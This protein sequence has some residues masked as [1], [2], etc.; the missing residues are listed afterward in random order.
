MPMIVFIHLGEAPLPDC[1]VDAMD[2]ARRISPGSEIVLIAGE[3]H[4]E[5]VPQGVSLVVAESLAGGEEMAEFRRRS[6]LRFEFRND[7]WFHTSARFFILAEFMRQT[8]VK[9]VI[10]LENDVVLHFDP[11]QRIDAFRAFAD[12]AVPLDRTRA[13]AGIVWCANA[14]AVSAL[15]RYMLAHP[16]INDMESVG[17]FCLANPELAR[18][19][20]TIPVEYAVARGLDVA[21]YCQGIDHFGGVFDAAAIGQYLGGIHWLNSPHD[22]RFFRNESSDLDLDTCDPVWGVRQGRRYLELGYGGRRTPVLAIHAHS[23]D[24]AG[25]S[26]FNHGVVADPEDVLTGERLQALADLT[27]S[28]PAITHFH[29]RVN[30]QSRDCVEIPQNEAG[31]LMVP[32]PELI[33]KCRQARVIFVYTHLMLYFKRY[34]APRLTRPFVLIAHNSDNGVGLDDLDL[35]NHPQLVRCWAQH[36]ETAHVRL[37]PLPSGMA[38]RQ[39]GAD[40]I[41]H[42]FAVARDIRKDGLLYA[43]VNPTHPSRAHALEVAGRL[44]GATIESN[45]DFGHFVAQL[46]RH[47]FCLCPRGNGIDSHRFWEALY[48]DAIPVVIR[49]DWISSYSGFPVVLLNSWDE[50]PLV[51]WR[52][53]Y[54]RIKST[55]YRFHG[56]SLRHL[57]EQI[58]SPLS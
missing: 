8:G 20:P 58:R 19:L 13:V 37:S 49:P 7:F 25:V 5:A 43:N 26:P 35:L 57:A 53:T 30:I 17:G 21:R 46:A 32:G 54:L 10:H 39:W 15:T 47:R 11:Q 12:F 51:D 48:L 42:V 9:D 38:N 28:S 52:K 22:T 56:L 50:L 44:P 2:V 16:G 23:K 33:E 34:I 4:A 31:Q 27:I 41:D 45:V 6:E 3:Q 55:A 36:P 14:E 18:P 24:V 29:G 40:R 1:A